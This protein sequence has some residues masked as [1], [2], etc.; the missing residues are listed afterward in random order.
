M[1]TSK[2]YRRL[3]LGLQTILI[4]QV[5]AALLKQH[6]A[7]A[8]FSSGIVLLTLIPLTLEKRIHVYLPPQ[9]QLLAII[10]VF[11]AFF[12]GELRGYYTRFWWWDAALHTAS[13]FLVGIFGIFLMCF[14]NELEETQSRVRAGFITFFAFVF[15]LGVGAAWEILEFAL[16]QLLEMNLQ[17]PMLGDPSGLTDTMID[18]ALDAFGAGMICLF[19][20]FHLSRPQTTSFLERWITAL[21]KNNAELIKRWKK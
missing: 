14:F 7:T 21:I 10:I 2:T 16:D 20:Y 3:S 17:K 6:W 4:I 1:A 5:L 8:F 12:L 19:G 11:S 15:A 9:F 18:L 13:G